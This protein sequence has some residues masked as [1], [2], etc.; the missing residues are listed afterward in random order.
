MH[1]TSL[2]LQII[3]TIVIALFAILFL[4]PLLWMISSSLKS[5][6]QVFT[7]PFR[8]FPEEI[9]WINYKK[10]WASTDMPLL[11]VFYNSL[12][13]T[14]FSTVG[15]LLFAS[16]AAYAFA[17]IQFR[18]KNILFTLF[19]LAS[20]MIPTQVTII[21]R[22][23]I[24]RT[25]GLYNSFWALILPSL[26]GASAIF[27]LRQS[28]KSL[29]NELVDAAKVDG[30][31][32]LT[33]FARI[34]VPLTIPALISMMVLTFISTWNDYLNPLIFLTKPKLFTISQAIRWYML[35]EQQRYEL[36]MAVAT[37]SIIPIVIIFLSCQKYFIEG[38]AKSGIKG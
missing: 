32:H 25:M 9:R 24:F 31:G 21:P 38:I 4:I 26:F 20:M 14:V 11:R 5:T 30:A 7:S 34:M 3:K 23:M 33:I 2:Q 22:F 36:T 1:R 28:H 29:P 19:F 12:F 6:N 15:Q 16:M 8:W 37:S 10:I 13:V 27:F 18:G 35:D 17:R